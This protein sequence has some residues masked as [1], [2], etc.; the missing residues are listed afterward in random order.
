MS[1]TVLHAPAA[2]GATSLR[3]PRA[4]DLNP[5]AVSAGISAFIFYVTAGVPLLI[6][7]AGRLGLDAAHTSSWFFIVFFTTATSSL[8]L[9]LRYRQPL[10][11]NWS[12]P[13]LLYLGSLAGHFTFAEL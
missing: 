1:S 6:A 8:V 4:R 5:A 13:G 10:P 7:V 3:W 11:M 2:A 9:T 12:L